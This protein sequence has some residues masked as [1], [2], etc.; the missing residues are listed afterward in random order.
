ML[1]PRRKNVPVS[2]TSVT[3]SYPR[4]KSHA[5]VSAHDRRSPARSVRPRRASSSGGMVC[6]SRARKLV[7]TA[8][9]ACAVA[10]RQSVRSRWWT[11]VPEGALASKCIV[12]RS[13]NASTR[14]SPSHP[15][16]S[17]LQRRARSSLGATSATVRAFCATSADQANARAPAVASATVSRWRSSSRDAR[18]RYPSLRSASSRMPPRRVLESGAALTIELRHRRLG[19]FTKR[20]LRGFRRAGEERIRDGAL[21]CFE[22][23]EHV[24]HEVADLAERIRRRDADA[25]AREVFADRGHDRAH[26]VV[27]ARSALPAK[28]DLAK[29]KIDLVEDHE[30][31]RWL[32][33]VAVEQLADRATGVVHERLWPRDRHADAIDRALRDPRVRGLHREVGARALCET[34]RDLETDVVAGVCLSLAGI[35][36]SDDDPVDARRRVAS[37]EQLRESRHVHSRRR[38]APFGRTGHWPLM[39]LLQVN[40]SVRDLADGPLVDRVQHEDR[41]VGACLGQET[42][43]RGE[44]LHGDRRDVARP[45]AGTPAHP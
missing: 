29:R 28:P 13:G 45:L 1:P 33:A 5:A 34:G 35:A 3:G 14:S 44:I 20:D 4:S 25:E 38:K 31:I 39:V 6:S 23:L 7:T 41:L 2:L 15:A 36:K 24:L 18:S 22:R 17:A 32:D 9:G 19:A 43:M 27:R 11:A 37:A 26:P 8:T 10:S 42:Q 40:D 16:S 30:Q 21:V 12:S